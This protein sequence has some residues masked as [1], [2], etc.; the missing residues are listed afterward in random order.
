MAAYKYK[1]IV[2][3]G[4]TATGKTRL[5]ARLAY[6]LDGEIISADSRQ[7][8]RGMDIGSGKDKA[9]YLINNREI[10]HHLIDIHDPGY[11]YNIHEFGRDFTR[12]LNE[13]QS[14]QKRPILCG[15][16]GLYIE[17]ALCGHAS[18]HTPNN[19]ILRE[20]LSTLGQDDLVARL[21]RNRPVHNTTD[22]T[23]RERL[24][25]AI[26]IS[27]ASTNN[28]RPPRIPHLMIGLRL[29]RQI[30]RQKI[31]NRLTNRLNDGLIEEVQ[32]LLHAGIKPESLTF[33]GLEYKFV[34]LY[35]TGKI[36][37]LQLFE[38]LNTAIHQFAKRQETWFRRMEKNGFIIH[39]MDASLP[40]DELTNQ[41]H[42]I[43]NNIEKTNG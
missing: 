28:L 13:I 9:D 29:E 8:Y 21:L 27:E 36:S 17:T 40:A 30:L 5:A 31:T 26:E 32:E 10:S 34:T 43:I 41:A 12:S 16:S 19:Q 37:Y 38:L 11:E 18:T 4:A 7:V 25:R 23:N 24:I 14:R 3:T 20:E 42:Q 35:V 33:Y 1:L 6:D 39:W 15:G 22:T 2:I